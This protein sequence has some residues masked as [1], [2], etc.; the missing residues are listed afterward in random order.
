M[1]DAQSRR[2]AAAAIASHYDR[3]DLIYGAMLDARRIYSCAL[4]QQAHDLDTAQLHKLTLIAAKLQ[5]S[6]G[7]RVLDIGCGWGGLAAFLAD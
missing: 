3:D 5:L 7:Q 2:R 6:P 1:G 4:W